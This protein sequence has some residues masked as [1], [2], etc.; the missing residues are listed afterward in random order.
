MLAA[1]MTNWTSEVEDITMI[2]T[3]QKVCAE[4]QENCCIC[5]TCLDLIDIVLE[6][7]MCR[8]GKKFVGSCNVKVMQSF[9]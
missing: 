7:E 3:Y 5:K 8:S 6:P 4:V 2:T 9:S 1:N